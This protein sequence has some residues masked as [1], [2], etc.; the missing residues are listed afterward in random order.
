MGKAGQ[1][2]WKEIKTP[3]GHA[4]ISNAVEVMKDKEAI[5]MAKRSLEWTQ[6]TA[7]RLRRFLRRHHAVVR[8]A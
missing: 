5:R 7:S 2:L 4:F 3:Q 6:E 1:E 8:R